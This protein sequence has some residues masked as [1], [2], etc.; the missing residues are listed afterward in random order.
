MRRSRNSVRSLGD[1]RYRVAVTVGYDPETGKQIRVDR[2]LRCKKTEIEDLIRQI[3]MEYGTVEA[4]SY[5]S[6]FIYDFIKAEY[7]PTR[8]ELSPTTRRG[9]E[10]T[11]RNHIQPIFGRIKMTDANSHTLNKALAR[12]EHPGARLNVW[13]MLTAA[14]RY[15]ADSG[16]VSGNPMAR[17]PR[18]KLPAY[19]ADVYSLEEAV[20]AMAAVRGLEIEPGI[21]IASSIG[22]RASETC[23]LDW[24]DLIM[25]QIV[26]AD[27][28]PTFRGVLRIDDSYHRVTGSRVQKQ[29]KTEKSDRANALP[30][31]VVERLMEL[32][33]DFGGTRRI[34]PLMVDRTGQRMTPDGFSHRWRRLTTERRNKAGAVIYTP[35][36]RHIEL[37]NLRHSRATILLALGATLREVSLSLGHAR[38]STTSAF[39]DRTT[40][41]PDFSNAER[42]D[43]AAREAMGELVDLGQARAKSR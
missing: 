3:E 1:G 42:L 9:Y 21:L 5:G 39:Y 11:L 37:K 14:F 13:K 34:G 38:E 35:P 18:P 24:Q 29:T 16:V 2:T 15:A 20:T 17:V 12:I 25:E 23:A 27:G 7:L 31:F 19:H 33:G 36:I 28:A 40:K 22:S 41:V 26:G 32:R 6:M 43:R 4:A 8:G 30:A 10:A